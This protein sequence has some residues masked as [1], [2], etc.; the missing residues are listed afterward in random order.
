[1]P[2]GVRQIWDDRLSIDMAQLTHFFLYMKP[3]C[4]MFNINVLSTFAQKCKN[5]S[6]ELLVENTGYPIPTT[7]TMEILRLWRS[8]IFSNAKNYKRSHKSLSAWLQCFLSDLF[9][10]TARDI[11]DTVVMWNEIGWWN[12]IF[13]VTST[14]HHLANESSRTRCAGITSTSFCL[15]STPCYVGAQGM[16]AWSLN[17]RLS[18]IFVRAHEEKK[19]DCQHLVWHWSDRSF[20]SPTRVFQGTIPLS[21]YI[22]SIGCF[23]AFLA[24]FKQSCTFLKVPRGG[25]RCGDRILPGPRL[26]LYR[27]HGLWKHRWIGGTGQVWIRVEVGAEIGTWWVCQ[28][29]FLG[30]RSWEKD[31]RTLILYSRYEA[32]KGPNRNAV[33]KVDGGF[34]WISDI[35]QSGQV[36]V[37]RRHQ[38]V[39]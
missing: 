20:K 1:M 9:H 32:R 24:F 28:H 26:C 38:L 11:G 3:L 29:K 16:A 35:P 27:H 2:E 34:K 10:R 21:G 39:S 22:K 30:W 13:F 7:W 31:F 8:Y 33:W 15:S 25:I 5:I 37:K 18:L 17:F 36:R 4:H 19:K 6:T 23:S 14:V 12:I